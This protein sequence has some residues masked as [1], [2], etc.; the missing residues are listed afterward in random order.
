VQRRAAGTHFEPVIDRVE[1]VD[2]GP[3]IAAGNRVRRH[4]AGAAAGAGTRRVGRVSKWVLDGL[5]D[6]IRRWLAG[7]E[8]NL[9]LGV[10]RTFGSGRLLDRENAVLVGGVAM[11]VYPF[12]LWTLFPVFEALG[13]G[14]NWGPGTGMLVAT[15]VVGSIL[16]SGIPNVG[17]LFFGA[18]GVVIPLVLWRNPEWALSSTL[19]VAVIVACWLPFVHSLLVLELIRRERR[20]FI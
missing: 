11:Y 17:L 20:G 1:S 5:F 10:L 6:P 16:L 3:V 2:W 4:P 13:T 14:A 12:L 7:Y 9:W 8:P 15:L 19:G 18:W